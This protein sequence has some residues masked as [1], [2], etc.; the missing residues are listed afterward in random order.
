MKDISFI[1]KTP[2]AHRGYHND[3]FP[4]NSIAA[5]KNAIKY[6]YTIELDVHLTKDNKLVVFHDNSLKR[7][8]GY[9]KSVEDFTYE[10]L[11]KF[12]LFD[13]KYK[14]PLLEEVLELVNGKVGLLIETK[15]IKFDGKL[16]NE[17][18]KLLDSYKGAFAIQSFNV[19][20]INWF[21]KNRN[22]YIRGLLISD[23]VIKNKGNLKRL[24]GKILLA[25]IYL[26]TNFISYDIRSLPNLFVKAKRKK[27]LVLSWNIKNKNDY[28]KAILY[29]DNIIGEN[30]ENYI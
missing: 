23:F 29:S 17:L 6:G 22:N 27:K 9:N 26:K 19:F 4:E 25:D 11:T 2:I 13:T 18:S 3:K 14:I 15:V 12:N 8:C 16:E 20:S 10:E 24:I 7:V 30:M 1:A 28:D 5:F 21:K